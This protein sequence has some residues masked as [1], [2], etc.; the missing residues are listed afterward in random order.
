MLTT[1]LAKGEGKSDMISEANEVK[2]HEL[3]KATEEK[4][5]AR[6]MDL[7]AR[8]I[9]LCAANA[10]GL[11]DVILEVCEKHYFQLVSF[12]KGLSHRDKRSNEEAQNK[13]SSEN[14]DATPSSREKNLQVK[15]RLYLGLLSFADEIQTIEHVGVLQQRN[16]TMRRT[17]QR[18]L[19]TLLTQWQLPSYIV[20]R[21]I[22]PSALAFFNGHNDRR[23][24]FL[25]LH[26]RR[27][28]YNRDKLVLANRRLVNSIAARYKYLNVS[29]D[30][31]VQ[32]G[33]L[34]LIKAVERFDYRRGFRF[35][36]YAYPT[37]HQF[38]HYAVERHFSIV[39]VPNPL[40][41]HKETIDS[42]VREM[43]QSENGPVSVGKLEA[44]LSLPRQDLSF[45][46][47][48]N[49]R[50]SADAANGSNEVVDLANFSRSDDRNNKVEQTTY[51]DEIEELLKHLSERDRQIVLMKF[52]VG[53]RKDYTLEE[54]SQ[55][56]NLS[57]ERVRQIVNSSIDKVSAAFQS[58]GLTA[59][60]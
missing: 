51:R 52:G 60:M 47:K 18:K 56:F 25:R 21:D 26:Q 31:L 34:G 17:R 14:Q 19:F 58:E 46:L 23:H 35:S 27:Y 11:L 28:I 30:D 36:S 22:L 2:S 3:L 33:H 10:S 57:R 40:M 49:V 50:T 59:S 8:N 13:L 24:A 5:L 29:F 41:R 16:E 45:V 37:I 6:N 55:T 12:N 44:A 43:E 53:V 15:E 38:I 54:L 48:H 4:R 7:A 20:I 1:L 32:E 39:R 9:L 42:M